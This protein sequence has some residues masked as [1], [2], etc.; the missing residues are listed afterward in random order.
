MLQAEDLWQCIA[1]DGGASAEDLLRW[2]QQG[3]QFCDP[4]SF[5]LE[6][7]VGGPCGILAV[8]QSEII[9]ALIDSELLPLD[10]NM[11]SLPIISVSD[12]I[13]ALIFA[14]SRIL[15]RASDHV[16]AYWVYSC[17]SIGPLL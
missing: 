2:R 10:V 13:S 6:Q 4:L 15:R 3:F 5:G 16:T 9:C 14:I 1:C 11:D 12:R 8:V 7:A 17:V